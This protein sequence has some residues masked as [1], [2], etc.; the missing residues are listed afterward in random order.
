MSLYNQLAGIPWPDEKY[1]PLVISNLPTPL[2]MLS[3]FA[4]GDILAFE[5]Y[6]TVALRRILHL[7]LFHLR[8]EVGD[9]AI[10]ALELGTELVIA[11]VVTMT[12]LAI[13]KGGRIRR[14]VGG[15]R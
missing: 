4:R 14:T 8:L 11:R 2:L 6:A 1:I 15:R 10:E 9:V 12:T 3:V 13:K 5:A 7:V